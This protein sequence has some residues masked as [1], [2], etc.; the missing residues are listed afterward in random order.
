V[1]GERAKQLRDSVLERMTQLGMIEPA[2]AAKAKL[3]E[4]GTQLGPTTPEQFA[5]FIK[6]EMDKYTKLIKEANIKVDN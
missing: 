3:E 5:S 1:R 4:A 6:T 2:Q